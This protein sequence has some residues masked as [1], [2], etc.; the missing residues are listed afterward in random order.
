MK[1]KIHKFFTEKIMRFSWQRVGFTLSVIAIVAGIFVGGLTVYGYVYRG[2]VLPNIYLGQID[3][4]GMRRAELKEFLG[5]M[6]DKLVDTGMHFVYEQNGKKGT[7]IIY[8]VLVA[9]GNSVELARFDVDKEADRLVDY[10]K[11]ESIIAIGWQ[12]MLCLAVKKTVLT[13]QNIN[14]DKNRLTAILAEKLQGNEQPPIDANVKILSLDPLDF[15]VTPASPGIVID[16]DAIMREA[17]YN[18]SVLAMK[19][20]NVVKNERQ[21]LISEEEV[22]TITYKLP[23]IFAGDGLQLNYRDSSSNLDYD[24]HLTTSQL[25]DWLEAQKDSDGSL[26]FGLKA[27]EINKFLENKIAPTV[28]MEARDAKFKMG[29][30]GKV[31]EF[32]G[33]RHGI[34]LDAARTRD[35]II[36]AFKERSLHEE[37]L[38]KSVTLSVNRVEPNVKT[39]DVNNLGISESLG[40]GVS[41]F[42]GSPTNRV[43]NI[44]AAVNKLNGVLIE[45]NEE[46]SALKFLQP[47]TIDGGYL[48][49]LVIKGDEI[50]P[51]IGGG[52]CQI[53]TTLFRMAMNSGMRIT[54]RRNHS[55]VVNYYNDPGN[56]NPGTDATVYDPA[57][58]FKFLNDTGNSV[59]IQTEMD[60]AKQKLYFTLWGTSDGRKAYYSRP[61]VLR[62]FKP[63]EKKTVETTKLK[64]GE[65]KCQ[66]AYP[67]ADASFTY[68]RELPGKEKEEIVYESHYRPLPE[69]CLVGVEAVTSGETASSTP[70]VGDAV[71]EG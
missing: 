7:L 49:E 30:N 27:G 62:W 33:S 16:Y 25:A 64:P 71:S 22:K 46:F 57:P 54:S 48:S 39:G 59:F 38:P 17:R 21:P 12:A 40:T 69:I 37:G 43:K 19:N 53:G 24:W 20:V 68:T 70:A 3:I 50:K 61:Q 36:E 8:P 6:S 52:L 44:R 2:R 34:E 31:V 13:A 11:G 10:G 66:H 32:Q 60:A 63:G 47:F 18:W 29:E 28:N 23:K 55:L 58:D 56:G 45:P 14:V 67:G 15:T 9:D 4:S 26:V 5:R 51:E 42:G 1:E 35:S 41:S 65:T